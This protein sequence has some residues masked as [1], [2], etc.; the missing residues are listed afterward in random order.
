MTCAV[1]TALC[2]VHGAVRKSEMGR[3]PCSSG[4]P[5]TEGSHAEE[6]VDQ[7]QDRS[8]GE[9]GGEL[10]EVPDSWNRR[11]RTG[12]AP[13]LTGR[14]ALHQVDPADGFLVAPGGDHIEIR[15]GMR[16]DCAGCQGLRRTLCVETDQLSFINC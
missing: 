5:K 8:L 3:Y 12:N 16:D 7:L 13:Y 4:S 14:S 15:E 11:W 10:T 2:G 6:G 1:Y 9:P